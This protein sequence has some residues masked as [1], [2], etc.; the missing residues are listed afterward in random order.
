MAHLKVPRGGYRLAKCTINLFPARCL[1]D[2]HPDTGLRVG[3]Y[4]PEVF[5]HLLTFVP[6]GPDR[7]CL[8]CLDA[9]KPSVPLG[10]LGV[11]PLS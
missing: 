3:V 1:R 2:K 5:R 11:R 6:T 4:Q 10:P 9:A 8:A 7:P